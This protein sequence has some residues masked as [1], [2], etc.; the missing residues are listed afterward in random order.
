MSV[1]SFAATRSPST[2]WTSLVVDVS[3][4]LPLLTVR[5]QARAF[6]PVS[7]S[8]CPLPLYNAFQLALKLPRIWPAGTVKLCSVDTLQPEL[9]ETVMP[10]LSHKGP[11]VMQQELQS[12]HAKDPDTCYTTVQFTSRNLLLAAGYVNT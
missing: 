5:F 4:R 10:S 9:T 1:E 7:N 2:L 11:D 3:W 8:G 12:M 6:L